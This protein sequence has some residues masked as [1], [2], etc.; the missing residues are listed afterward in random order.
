LIKTVHQNSTNVSGKV[1]AKSLFD[2]ILA[3]A[4]SQSHAVFLQSRVAL[5]SLAVSARGI[6]LMESKSLMRRI[7]GRQLQVFGQRPSFLF[8]LVFEALFT[9]IF[10]V[11]KLIERAFL[12]PHVVRQGGN[13]VFLHQNI[14]VLPLS[15]LLSLLILFFPIAIVYYFAMASQRI[16]P[17]IM[18]WLACCDAAELDIYDVAS[19]AKSSFL[20][21]AYRKSGAYWYTLSDTPFSST[22]ELLYQK[23]GSS[24]TDQFVPSSQVSTAISSSKQ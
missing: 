21:E 24:N 17:H 9:S 23:A 14:H 6:V 13:A 18:L 3:G 8:L 4:F 11:A 16:I 7:I 22:L 1:A 2:L 20:V 15:L 10:F 5:A 12:L 19:V